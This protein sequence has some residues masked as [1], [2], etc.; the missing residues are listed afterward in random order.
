[1]TFKY[2]VLGRFCLGFGLL[3]L[4]G[5]CA[6][7]GVDPLLPAAQMRVNGSGQIADTGFDAIDLVVACNQIQHGI[8]TVPEIAHHR[9]PVRIAVEPVVNDTRFAVDKVTFDD[10]VLGQLRFRAPRTRLFMK[11]EPASGE[12][13]D[14]YLGGR[15]QRLKPLAPTDHVILLYS[16]QLIDARNSEIN[17]EGS[18]EIDN[19]TL[20]L[21]TDS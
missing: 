17:W 11:D 1:M 5:G 6:T 8:G 20:G 13:V 3:L 4:L 19:H 2:P 15:L 21:E 18:A 9:G 14:Y 7:P 16:F 10:A 12:G